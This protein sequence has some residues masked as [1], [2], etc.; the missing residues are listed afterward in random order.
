MRSNVYVALLRGINVGGKNKLPMKDLGTVFADL[1][2]EMIQTYIQTGN[3]IFD[4]RPP[5]AR[6][7]PGLVSAALLER[8]GLQVPVIVRTAE[9]LNRILRDNPYV[10]KGANS[11]ALHVSFL[12]DRPDAERTAALD[13]QRSPGDEFVVRGSEIYLHCPNGLARTKLTN[14]YFDSRLATTSTMRNW[15]TV[16]KLVEMAGG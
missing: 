10:R 1:G 15:N 4:A 14:A 3:I 6:R 5:L 7:V 12:A 13:P 11:K 16:R 8:F 2:C 9:Q